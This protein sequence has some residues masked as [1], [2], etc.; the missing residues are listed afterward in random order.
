MKKRGLIISVLVM[1]AVITSGF[2]Y[3]FWAA[4]VAGGTDTALGTINIGAGQEAETT[5]DIE[6]VLVG[7][8][9]VPEGFVVDLENETDEVNLQF[10]VLWTTEAAVSGSESVGELT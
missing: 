9:L 5:V 7:K 1:L 10:S 6:D 2:T 8:K 3:A 4:S